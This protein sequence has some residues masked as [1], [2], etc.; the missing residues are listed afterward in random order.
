MNSNHFP[1]AFLKT[2]PISNGVHKKVY[3]TTMR[4]ETTD[5][6]PQQKIP[7]LPMGD[8]RMGKLLVCSLLSAVC[9]LYFQGRRK[10]DE[11]LDGKGFSAN[12]GRKAEFF[13]DAPEIFAAMFW[14]KIMS[15]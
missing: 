5:L 2:L 3:Y 13:E 12:L 1:E 15:Q 7:P 6:R 10:E 14:L 9:R 8:G 11:F 4:L